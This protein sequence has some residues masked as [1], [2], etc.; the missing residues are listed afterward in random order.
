MIKTALKDKVAFNQLLMK[1]GFTLKSFAV[2]ANVG[3]HSIQQVSSGKRNPTAP[4]AFK[5]CK[6]LGMEFDDLFVFV[7]GGGSE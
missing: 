5:I 6:G 7:H 3:Y 2:H 4:V 1:E